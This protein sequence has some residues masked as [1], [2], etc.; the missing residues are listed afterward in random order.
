VP[1]RSN[2][3]ARIAR[4]LGGDSLTASGGAVPIDIRCLLEGACRGEALLQ[5]RAGG[6]AARASGRR[7]LGR[8]RLRIGPGRK[9]TVRVKLNRAGRRLVRRQRTARLLAVVKLGSAGSVKR[10]VEVRRAR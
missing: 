2:Q 8:R 1:Q 10:R 7:V 4:F 5:T 3:Q 6:A 9:A